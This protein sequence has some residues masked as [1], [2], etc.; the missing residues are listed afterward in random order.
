[1]PLQL[2]T[3][4]TCNEGSTP[5]ILVELTDEAGVAVPDAQ[6]QSVTV[7]VH[8]YTSG[9]ELRAATAAT[10][11]G[12]SSPPGSLKRRRGSSTPRSSTSTG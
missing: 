1:M 12:A 11:S 5:K 10:P 2:E 4:L 7:A 3:I 9:E 6:I 8:D